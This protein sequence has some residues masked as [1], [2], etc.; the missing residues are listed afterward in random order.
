MYKKGKLPIIY[1][2]FINLEINEE[3][4]KLRSDRF[5]PQFSDGISINFNVDKLCRNVQTTLILS[6]FTSVAVSVA[7]FSLSFDHVFAL[8]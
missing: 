8:T 3:N 7:V 6:K 1:F 5:Q 4:E 2:Y